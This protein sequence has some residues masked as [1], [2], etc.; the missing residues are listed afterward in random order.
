MIQLYYNFKIKNN[1][2]NLKS[3]QNPLR[4]HEQ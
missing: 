3:N 2:K 4:N 1:F